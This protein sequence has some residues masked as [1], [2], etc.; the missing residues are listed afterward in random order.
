VA[1]NLSTQ[2]L[3]SFVAIVDTGTMLNAAEQVFLSQSALSLQIKRLEEL[4]QQPLFM[5]DGRRLALTP[6]GETLL[7]YARRILRI[8]DEAVQLLSSGDASGPI[9]VGTVQDFA[10]TL[11]TGVLA[12]FA[13]LHPDT[14]ISAR[15]AGTAELREM[16]ERDQLDMVFGYAAADDPQALN[17]VPTLWYGHADLSA[18]PVLPLVVLETPCRFREAAIAALD[19][20]GRPWRVAVETPNLS[21]LRAAVEAGLGVTCRTAFFLPSGETI[22][23]LPDLPRV[24]CIIARPAE[25]APPKE[26]L[27]SLAAEV[28]REL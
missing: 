24:A 27:A 10:E 21:T 17:V 2:L 25:L 6:A 22:E 8:H 12:R 4:V 9:R 13:S 15:V 28:I 20:A 14:Q 19:A 26:R 23:D 5:R 7:D 18:R 16:L 3:R 11:L 1:V